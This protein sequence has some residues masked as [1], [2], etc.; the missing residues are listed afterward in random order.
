MKKNIIILFVALFFSSNINSQEKKLTIIV[1]D[2]DNKAVAGAIIL[3]DNV[4]QRIWT[5][6]SGMFKTKI[7]TEPREVSAFHPNI[8]IKTIKYDGQNKLT[9]VIKGGDDLDL[10]VNSVKQ[11]MV[12]AIQYNTIYDYLRGKVSGLNVSSDG[13][14]RIRGYNSVNGNMSPL[15]ILNGV[16]VSKES[17][18]A[19]R[20]D[21]IKTI[22][23]L[24]G[25]ETSRYGFR[26]ANGVIIVKTIF[27]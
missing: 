24:K 15:L 17:F 14:I 6:S 11:K 12:N 3:F 23:V 5:N 21:D 13:V 7:K 2:I 18:S 20:P 8:G 9:I 22:T 26:G 27:I 10:I 1:K 16:E 19:I 4:K 25:P